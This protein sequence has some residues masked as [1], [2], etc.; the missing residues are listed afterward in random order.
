[1]KKASYNIV[2]IGTKESL[3]RFVRCPRPQRPKLEAG[4]ETCCYWDY[5]IHVY[6]TRYFV[7]AV[8]SGLITLSVYNPYIVVVKYA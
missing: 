5:N 8:N 1:M 6:Q 2:N 4:P 7:P 3:P